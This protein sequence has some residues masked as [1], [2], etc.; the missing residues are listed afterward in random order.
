[1]TRRLTSSVA[2]AFRRSRTMFGSIQSRLLFG[3]GTLVLLLAFAVLFGRRSMLEM[4]AIIRTTLDEVRAESRLSGDLATGVLQQL[5]S[6]AHYLE[7]GDSAAAADFRELGWQ[8]HRVQ[9]D[10]N[11]LPSQGPVEVALIA[12]IDN[13]LSRIEVHYAL[14]HRL[15]ELGRPVQARRAALEAR[16]L[17]DSLFISMNSLSRIKAQKLGGAV[18][19]LSGDATER[20]WLLIVVMVTALVL[21][22]LGVLWIVGSISSHLLLLVKQARQLSEGDLTARTLTPMPGEFQVLADALN[23]TGESLST[24]VSVV[25][26]TADDV[27]TSAQDLAS[28]SEQISLSASQMATAMSD[29]TS[30]AESQAVQL[31]TVDQALQAI[32]ERTTGVRSGADEVG[33]LAQAIE[34]AAEAKRSEIERT[35]SILMDVRATVREAATEVTALNDTAADINK[36][37]GVVSRIAEQTN[38][39]ALNAAIEAARA[40]SAGRGFAV[41][42]DEVRKLAEQAQTAADDIVQM[43]GV[44]TQRVATTSR[45][46]ELGVSR[47]GEIERVSREIDDALTE[48]AGSAERTRLAAANVT[49][50]AELNVSMA[51]EAA[52]DVVAVARTAEGHAATAQEV[53][54]ATEEQSAACEQMNSAS[55]QLMD[56]SGLLRELVKGLKTA[57]AI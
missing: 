4:S 54:A 48:I 56:G 6:A 3:F 52:N 22:T 9:R 1:M 39:L 25:V 5:E 38:L 12:S 7:T 47:V 49:A 23:H 2:A 55:N 37:V 34:D 10:M 24:I 20:S 44:V 19:N 31:R 53:G 33:S 11:A 51:A 36:F 29:V 30:G 14:A 43:T 27:A 41:V 45:A 21:G 57:S 15:A 16:E 28:V 46:M 18:E 32:R 40:G 13:T 8:S 50:V 42:A 17:S 26:K 35:L